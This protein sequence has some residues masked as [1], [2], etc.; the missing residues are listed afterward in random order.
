MFYGKLFRLAAI[1]IVLTVIFSGCSILKSNDGVADTSAY[2][3]IQK[4]LMDMKSYQAQAQVKYISNKNEN[5]YDTLQQCKITGE[6]RIEVTGPENVKGN[7]TLSD[8][9]T[10]CQFNPNVSSKIAVGSKESPERSEIFL[11]SFIK[12]Y[13]NSNEVSLEVANFGEGKATV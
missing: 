4:T 11:T 5:E 9:K 8:G 10:I 13:V 1:F 12:N 3:K 2:E 7:V 6:Y